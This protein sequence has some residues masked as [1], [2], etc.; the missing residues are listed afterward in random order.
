M[1]FFNQS[2]TFTSLVKNFNC[3]CFE[4]FSFSYIYA[5]NYAETTAKPPQSDPANRPAKIRNTQG[6]SYALCRLFH[7]YA[8][9]P[10]TP[11]SA[12]RS[13]WCL[14]C[15]VA[16]TLSSTEFP[17]AF[18]GFLHAVPSSPAH[19]HRSTRGAGEGCCLSLSTRNSDAPHCMKDISYQEFV[20]LWLPSSEK[21]S[22]ELK[23]SGWVC[24][25][26]N[27]RLCPSPHD[28]K[29][30]HVSDASTTYH[31]C[32]HWGVLHGSASHDYERRWVGC[33]EFSRSSVL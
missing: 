13:C 2:E 18:C 25:D 12:L 4:Q 6:T 16:Q 7:R 28:E 19:C 29:E 1:Q 17:L 31:T 8:Y 27:N 20:R 21:K 11:L 23:K 5:S 9:T 14:L 15:F 24:K 32:C 22:G 3:F 10:I 30:F 33:R 26:K